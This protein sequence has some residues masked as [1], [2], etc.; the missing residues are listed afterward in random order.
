MRLAA[1][2]RSAAEPEP[3]PAYVIARPAGHGQ[4]VCAKRLA[5]ATG[6]EYALMSGGGV[7]RRLKV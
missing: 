1:A 2:T 4:D 3:L 5:K 6:L 7:G